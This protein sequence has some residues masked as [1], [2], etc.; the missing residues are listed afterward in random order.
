MFVKIIKSYRDIVA[1]CDSDLIGRRFEEENRQIDVKE[2]FFRGEQ[3]PEEEV[4]EIMSE[5]AKED[6]T[7]NIVGKKSINLA[8]KVGIISESGIKT[9][10]GIP[11][12]LVLM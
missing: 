2:S 11:F 12:A 6:A 1:I 5:M 7:F 10:Q 8:L 3:L 9:V 4:L